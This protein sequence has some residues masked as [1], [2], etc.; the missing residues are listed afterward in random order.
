M[1]LYVAELCPKCELAIET[2]RQA[3]CIFEI[4]KNPTE[5]LSLGIKTAPCLVVD[6]KKYGLKEI[7]QICKGEGSFE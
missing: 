5:A 7:L 1:K 6:G 2:L 4:V 3:G